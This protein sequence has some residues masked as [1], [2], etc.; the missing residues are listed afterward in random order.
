MGLPNGIELTYADESEGFCAISPSQEMLS[1]WN[2]VTLKGVRKVGFIPPVRDPDGPAI[3][4]LK[5]LEF[6]TPSSV[7]LYQL[8]R[9]NQIVIGY[10]NQQCI[11]EYVFDAQKTLVVKRSLN[12]IPLAGIVKSV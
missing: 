3:G 10:Q 6:N 12:A 1:N 5:P 11:V 7:W 4:L 9:T 2:A 8:E